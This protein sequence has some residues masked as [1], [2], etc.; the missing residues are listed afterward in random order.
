MI[1]WA[2]TLGFDVLNIVWKNADLHLST[3]LLVAFRDLRKCVTHDCDNHIEGSDSAEERGHDKEYET[4]LTL[5][6]NFILF[7]WVK[8]TQREQVLVDEDV[9]Y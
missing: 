5:L 1:M 7:Q 2:V 3:V 9:E 4:D 6:A 8:V